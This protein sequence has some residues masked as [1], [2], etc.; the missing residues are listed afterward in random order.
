MPGMEIRGL[1]IGY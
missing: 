1:I